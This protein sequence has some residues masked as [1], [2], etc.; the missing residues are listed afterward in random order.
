MDN[1]YK[2]TILD[3]GLKIVT[4]PMMQAKSVTAT[5]FVGAGQRYET[6]EINGISHFLEH[7]FFKGTQKRPAAID[8][9]STI[10][11]IG[12]EFNAGTSKEYTLFYVKSA[13][14]H[15]D[16]DLDVL[17]DILRNSKF[18]KEEIEREKGVVI[19][20]INM[21][22]DLPRTRVDDFY[23]QLLWPKN[24]LGWTVLGK[25]EVIR[26]IERENFLSYMSSLYV[27]NNM[28][29]GIAGNFDESQVIEQVKRCFGDLPTGKTISYLKAE[30]VQ[31]KPAVS[32]H[33]KKTDQAHLVLGVRSY[34]LIHKEKYNIWVL[35][36]VLGSG[37]SSRLFMNVR[38]RRGL[39]YYVRSLLSEYQDV[40]SLVAK[41]GVRLEK[42]E[43]AVTVILDEFARLFRA[44]GRFYDLGV[45]E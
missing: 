20:E 30:E 15:L 17:S 6:P 18:D 16:L 11:G 22:E 41:A 35:A 36:T 37:A 40:G 8:I 9:S 39:A 5:V 33:W 21:Y 1:Q 31:E 19:E 25:K 3:N 34:P 23:D 43:E 12:G 27:P 29:V 24:P 44:K 28:I 2:K 4:V 7:M 13:S 14:N 38:E 32:L 45:A 26:G 42:I 10:D